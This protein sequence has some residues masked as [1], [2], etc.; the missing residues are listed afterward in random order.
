MKEKGHHKNDEK[1][2]QRKQSFGR[3]HIRQGKM[4]QTAIV[5]DTAVV[6]VGD[7]EIEQDIKNDG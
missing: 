5:G 7:T 1:V 2:N 6:K 3:N 4:H